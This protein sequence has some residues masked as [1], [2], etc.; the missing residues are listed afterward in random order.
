[1]NP[2][3][4]ALIHREL[5]I[6]RYVLVGLNDVVLF[7]GEIGPRKRAPQSEHIRIS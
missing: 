7:D 1:M 4:G 6:N 2:T 5:V 3:V